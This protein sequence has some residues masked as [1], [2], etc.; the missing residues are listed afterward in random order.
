MQGILAYAPPLAS[1]EARGGARLHDEVRRLSHTAAIEG[2]VTRGVVDR[3]SDADR[4]NTR[5]DWEIGTRWC[6][7]E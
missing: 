5:Y 2:P 7:S 6:C 3:E 1:A 4:A